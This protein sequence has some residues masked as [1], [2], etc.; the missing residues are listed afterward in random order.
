MLDDE[1]INKLTTIKKAFS[2]ECL[3]EQLAE[4]C[5]ELAR[6]ALKLSRHL[7]GENQPRET[8]AESYANFREEI[9]DVKLTL[10]VIGQGPDMAIYSAKLN[11]FHNGALEKRRN[12]HDSKRT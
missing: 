11:R 8:W 6:A 4:E 3:Y 1:K 12:N 2:E 5:S 9:T 10:D 7:R